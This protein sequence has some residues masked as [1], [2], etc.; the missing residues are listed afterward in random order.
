MS[1][2]EKQSH[3]NILDSINPQEFGKLHSFIKPKTE[4]LR[5]TEIPWEINLWQARQK[6]GQ[7]NRP[8]FIWAMNGNPLGC[9]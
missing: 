3:Q 1:Y 5:W 2:Q 7:Q 9:T 4:E 6:A 8:L